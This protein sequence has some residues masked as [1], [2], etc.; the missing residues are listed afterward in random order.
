MQPTAWIIWY[1]DC[2]DVD[3]IRDVLSLN[4]PWLLE[5]L[6]SKSSK[7]SSSI[8]F[9][10]CWSKKSKKQNSIYWSEYLSKCEKLSKENVSF[11][12]SPLTSW[13]VRDTNCSVKELIQVTWRW[14]MRN[15]HKPRR[16]INRTTNF[17]QLF[18]FY[19]NVGGGFH[20]EVWNHGH[21]WR[22]NKHTLSEPVVSIIKGILIEKDLRVKTQMWTRVVH[23]WLQELRQKEYLCKS[24]ACISLCQLDI[25]LRG[26]GAY[27]PVPQHRLL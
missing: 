20:D 18:W 6:V 7:S 12:R 10:D 17:F 15:F 24:W 21:W 3:S 11:F 5:V 19:D 4:S 14:W 27:E 13:N 16:W 26:Q 22:P 25:L 8:V 9:K 23:A 2:V 1:E